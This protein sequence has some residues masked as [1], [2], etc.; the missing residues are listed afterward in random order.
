[1]TQGQCDAIATAERKRDLALQDAVECDAKG[2][3]WD[4][5]NLRAIAASYEA[6][7]VAVLSKHGSA[8]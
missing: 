6:H 1:M 4:A 3:T 8:D 2:W 7:R 5:A